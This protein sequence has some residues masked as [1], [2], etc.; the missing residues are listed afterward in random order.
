MRVVW[1]LALVAGC[2]FK[3]QSG[4]DDTGVDA[5]PMIDDAGREIVTWT[6]DTAADF[7]KPGAFLGDT[8]VEPWGSVTS[9]AY[10]PGG[11]VVRGVASALWNLGQTDA[12][13]T[14][15]PV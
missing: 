12:Q 5:P 1:L 7:T 13:L 10:L 3:S 6:L 15:T 8:G 4:G 14:W 2:G 9:G 11:V